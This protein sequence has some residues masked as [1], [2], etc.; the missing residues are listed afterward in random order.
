M[1]RSDETLI[2]ELLKARKTQAASQLFDIYGAAVFGVI[3]SKTDDRLA[4]ETLL[5][6]VFV[7]AWK[8]SAEFDATKESLLVWLLKITYRICSSHSIER[9]SALQTSLSPVKP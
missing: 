7:I 6:E 9:H 4:A 1:R 8:Q 2:T 5:E 3:C